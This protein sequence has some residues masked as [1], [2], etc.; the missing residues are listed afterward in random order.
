MKKLSN[1]AIISYTEQ[2][3]PLGCAGGYKYELNG[4]NLFE[5]VDTQDPSSII[6]LPTLALQDILSDIKGDKS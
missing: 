1:D 6:G 4:K 3:Q 2:D 5:K